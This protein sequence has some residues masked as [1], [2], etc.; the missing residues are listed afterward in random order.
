ML[1]RPQAMGVTVQRESPCWVV[2]PLAPFCS[3]PHKAGCP[4]GM[5]GTLVIHVLTVPLL[6]LWK[7]GG[8]G[9]VFAHR[10]WQGWGWRHRVRG[11]AEAICPGQ[12]QPSGVDVALG[13]Q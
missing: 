2:I 7:A 3:A 8:S 4:F 9:L 6:R 10:G 5:E 11:P 1:P 12:L 13:P